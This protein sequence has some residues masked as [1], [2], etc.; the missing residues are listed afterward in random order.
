M[1]ILFLNY[2]FPP[3]GGGASPISYDIA[4][5]YAALGHGV[6][7]VTMA[8][9]GLPAYE[10]REGLHIYRIA[11]GR[12][13]KEMCSPDEML[14]YLWNAKVF[15]K[16]H[17]QKNHYEAT[18]VHF[19]IPTGILAR[20]V[21]KNYNIPY[22][23]TSHGS[24]IPHYN[25]DRFTFLHRFTKP[26]LRAVA[27]GSAGNFAGSAYLAQLAN[28]QLQPH[29]P[30]QVIREGFDAATFVPLPKKQILLSSGRLLPRKGFRNLIAAVA[31]ETFPFELH[32]CGDGPDRPHL[33]QLAAHSA[34][35]VVF[36]G[37]LNNESP[38][39]RTL[40]GEAA[41][42]SLISSKEN[43]SKALLEA[44]SAGCAVLT[45]NVSGCPETVGDSG[46]VLPPDDIA[47]LQNALR[48]LAQHPTL[49]QQLGSAAR[50]RVLEH[51]DWNKTIPQYIAALETATHSVQVFK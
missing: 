33:E 19:A 20:W 24:D 16:N 18:H 29:I 41:I 1:N 34:T 2:E 26:L 3:L 40:L 22:I 36:H 5:H 48:N 37:W 31:A 17:L 42:Y 32:I 8:F 6:A 35:P 43:A 27:N 39:Y 7:V 10:V 51:Y 38:Q 9:E 15:L 11:A 21:K 23:L 30:Y 12:R 44:M 45:S 47:A 25:Q 28:Q 46:I 4:R 13:K 14:R 50:R 49:Q